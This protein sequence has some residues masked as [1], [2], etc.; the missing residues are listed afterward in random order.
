MQPL[1][2]IGAA[3]AEATADTLVFAPG[4]LV[5]IWR[6]VMLLLSFMYYMSNRLVRCRW[7]GA[8]AWTQPRR[9]NQGALIGVDKPKHAVS[10]YKGL[11]FVVL[12][13]Q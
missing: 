6:N 2:G 4:V 12:C 10:F 11:D 8:T 3:C 1:S 9:L 7:L 5:R 13:S